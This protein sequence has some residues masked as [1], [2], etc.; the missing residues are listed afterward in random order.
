MESKE[1][2]KFRKDIIHNIKKRYQVTDKEL[3][4]VNNVLLEAK[5]PT[6]NIQDLR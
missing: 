3:E 2:E 5:K 6:T 1:L 4:R